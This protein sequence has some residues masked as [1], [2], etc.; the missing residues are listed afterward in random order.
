MARKKHGVCALCLQSREL[1]RSHFLGR[2]IQRLNGR[3]QVIMTPQLIA[4]TQ[5]QLWRH[6]LCGECEGR[7][8]KNGEMHALAFLP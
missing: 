2:A 5:R 3:D 4:P 6:L 8:S 7:F 1:R